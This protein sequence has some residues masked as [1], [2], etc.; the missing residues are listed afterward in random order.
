MTTRR[1]FLASGVPF[2]FKQWGEWATEY[3][4]DRNDPD[5]RRC[6]PDNQHPSARYLNLAGG[7]GFHG[8]R[9]V[10]VRK[11]GK[12]VAGRLLDGRTWDDMPSARTAT[13]PR[14]ETGPVAG[15]QPKGQPA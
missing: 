11:V 3:D 12:T 7:H 1:E 13:L 14:R 6:P 15:G 9:V 8:E 10:Y 5:W 4:R 2:F